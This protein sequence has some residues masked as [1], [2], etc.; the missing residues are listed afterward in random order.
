MNMTGLMFLWFK[1]HFDYNPI[2]SLQLQIDAHRLP[3]KVSSRFDKHY[4]VEQQQPI[5]YGLLCSLENLLM[6]LSLEYQMTF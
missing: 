6:Q 2:E 4:Y 5:L 3:R 1:V